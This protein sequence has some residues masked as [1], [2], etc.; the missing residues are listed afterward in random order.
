MQLAYI[1]ITT[2]LYFHH[3]NITVYLQK[4]LIYVNAFSCLHAMEPG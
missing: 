1:F 2:G 4:A 3:I